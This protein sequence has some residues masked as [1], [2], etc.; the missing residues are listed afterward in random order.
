MDE[1]V[2]NP[3]PVMI[4][5]RTEAQTTPLTETVPV[6]PWLSIALQAEKAVKEAGI[7]KRLAIVGFAPTRN[8]APCHDPSW[9]VWALNDLKLSRE[10]R[11]FD[12]HNLN[13]IDTDYQAGRISNQARQSNIPEAVL[14][15]IGISGLAK[16]TIPV[17]MQ[18]KFDCVPMSVKL[19]LQ[20]MLAT[21][22]SRGLTGARYFT[23]SI[24]YMLAYAIYEGLVTGHQWDEIHIYGV[25]MAVGEEYVAQRPS[26]EY[27]IGI[28]EGMGIKM[29]IPDASD[30]N[31]TAFL[32]AY[33]EEPQKAYEN[34]LNQIKS[35]AMNRMNS[36]QQQIGELSRLMHHAE[37]QIGTITDLTRV[38][39]NND[40]KL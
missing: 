30:L 11:H 3:E 10:T 40:T 22:K 20:E 29:Y 18:E 32:Y 37:A 6:E 17:Y 25:D 21:F 38:W 23:N 28:A 9:E 31:K 7:K 27:W 2:I 36:Y 39:S 35:D 15:E 4:A 16:R 33:D 5:E 19:P 24:S 26:C 13:N 8:Q 1:N 34:K 12:I 14:S